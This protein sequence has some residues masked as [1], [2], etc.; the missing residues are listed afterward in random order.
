MSGRHKFRE[1]TQD[2]TPDRRQRIE[3]A[4]N[5]LLADMALHELR[6]ALRVTQQE[7]AETLE[8]HQPAIAKIEKRPDM[9][10][11][12]LCHYIEALG[13]RV[14]IVAQFPQGEVTITNFAPGEDE[15]EAQSPTQGVGD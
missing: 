6:R 13:G 9:Y 5:D 7:L 4:K 10:I 2:F 12:T 8:L 11:S 14:K 1:L 15:E 3:A